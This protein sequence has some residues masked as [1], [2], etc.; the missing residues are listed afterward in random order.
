MIIDDTPE[1]VVLSGFDGVRREIARLTARSS[2]P[3]GASTRRASRRSYYQAKAEIEEEIVRA[4][5][6]GELRG[7]RAG[8]H[9]ELI[10]LLGRLR[11]RTSYGQNVLRHSLECTHI[12]AIMAAEL[13]ASLEDDAPRR[14]A[15]RHRQGRRRTRS[16]ARTP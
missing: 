4:R 14:A 10:K 1:A 13:G 5:R 15:A 7:R 16:R 3:T 12:A 8:L 6:A 9:P 2:S 11:Y